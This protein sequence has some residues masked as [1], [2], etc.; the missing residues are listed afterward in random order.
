MSYIT[1][2]LKKE[3]LADFPTFKEN[4][5]KFYNKEIMIKDYKGMSGPFGSYAERGANTG[6]SR[7]RFP[8]GRISHEH[9]AFTADMIRKYDLKHAHFTTGQTIQ[10]HGLDGETIINIFEDCH[11]NGI[12]NRGGGGDHPRN[13]A[14]SPLRGVNPEEYWDIS[15]YVTAAGEYVMT[16]VTTIKLPRKLKPAFSDGHTN[17]AHVTIKDIGFKALPNGTFEV[18]AAGGMGP[19]SRLGTKIAENV[20]PENVL[21]YIKAMAMLFAENGDFKNRGRNRTRY[22]PD[23]LGG[24]EAFVK[25]FNTYLTQVQE[26]ENLIINPADFTTTIT[27]TGKWDETLSDRRLVKQKQQGLYA[28]AYHPIGGD[29]S[30]E[31]FLALL[32]YLRDVEASE[33]RLS[34]E[35]FAYII[36]LNAEEARRVLELTQNTARNAFESSVSCVGATVCQVGFQDSHGLLETLI[37]EMRKNNVDTSRLPRLHISGC[38]SSCGTHQIGSIG[39]HG[40]VKLVNKVPTPAFVVV[41]GGNDCFGEEKLGTVANTIAQARIIDFMM[42]LVEI[43]NK[44]QVDFNAWLPA[45]EGAF[46]ELITKYAEIDG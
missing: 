16:L 8:A 2:K 38:P 14:A 33:I 5:R 10:F 46:E 4:T 17:E 6:M 30:Q 7:W 3:L 39:F 28:V 22:L 11:N 21:Y 27:K 19:N 26:Q 13:V 42:E 45:N 41:Y 25:L 43:L 9:I 20:A 18:Y 29:P 15:P 23:A 35:E 34:N 37:A 40:S 36:N 31:E 44:E 32:D 24:E 1:E 12:Y